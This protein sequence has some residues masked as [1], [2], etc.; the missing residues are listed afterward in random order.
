MQD[1]LK[2]WTGPVTG[3]NSSIPRGQLVLPEHLGQR[4]GFGLDP[5]RGAVAP[6]SHCAPVRE[7][8][9]GVPDRLCREPYGAAR[10]LVQQR[11][12]GSG[13]TWPVKRPAAGAAGTR[14]LGASAGPARPTPCS[15]SSS[16][17]GCCTR[18]CRRGCGPRPASTRRAVPPGTATSCRTPWPWC[19]AATAGCCA[20]QIVLC[21][22]RQF[23]EGDVQH[24]WHAPGGAGRA[25]AVLGRP[26]VAALCLVRTTCAPRADAGP[27]S[28][29]SAPFLEGR[30][31]RRGWRRT[32][33]DTPR[34]S[35]GAGQRCTNTPHAPSTTAC[36]VGAHGLPLMGGG[37]WNDGMNRVGIEGRGESV[38]L[39]WFLC[40]HR[41]RLAAAGAR[42]QRGR[43][44]AA[45]GS[46]RLQGWRTR[47]WQEPGL[48]RRVVPARLF[49]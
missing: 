44:G 8:G 7:P 37:D 29:S 4:S 5:V 15:T 45:L 30:H 43:P 31:A 36:R 24:W 34:V 26:L 21:A 19:G 12:I 25:H 33:Y 3:A 39:A 2:A 14:L 38:W 22:S 49:R 23:A 11:A 13:A 17:A 27:C 40:H 42:A 18:P 48:G 32:I 1:S 41:G 9:A 28:R 46:R 16:T 35:T 6:A 47:R 20:T 10:A